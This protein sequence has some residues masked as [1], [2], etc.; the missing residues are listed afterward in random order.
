MI[1]NLYLSPN[2]NLSFNQHRYNTSYAATGRHPFEK[3]VSVISKALE[4]IVVE[5][6]KEVVSL[7]Y[8]YEKLVNCGQWGAAQSHP[9]ILVEPDS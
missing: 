7:M 9:G 1:S 8:V 4:D 2:L 3:F 5:S 6:K